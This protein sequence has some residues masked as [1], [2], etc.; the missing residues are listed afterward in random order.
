[1]FLEHVHDLVRKALLAEHDVHLACRSNAPGVAG[2]AK[3]AAKVVV[4]SLDSNY[5]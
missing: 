2:F 3:L 5:K 4:D 1:M